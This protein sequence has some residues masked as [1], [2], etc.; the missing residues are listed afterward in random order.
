[1]VRKALDAAGEEGDLL[2]MARPGLALHDRAG[3]LDDGGTVE[4]GLQLEGNQEGLPQSVDDMG[5]KQRVS[6]EV[7]EVVV[8]ADL[9]ESEQFLPGGGDDLLDLVPGGDIGGAQLGAG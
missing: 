5:G 7:E 8:D 1:M 6:A 4:Q 3:E 9:L 2:R